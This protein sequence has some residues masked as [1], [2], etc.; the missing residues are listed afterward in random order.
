M[1]RRIMLVCALA[2]VAVVALVAAGCGGGNAS[3]GGGDATKLTLV[4]Y[5]TPQEAYEEIIPAFQK[6]SAGKNVDFEQSYAASG[7]QS[8]AVEA[9]LPADVVAFSLEPDVTRLVD[10]G[11]V[12]ADWAQ[13]DH[14]GMVTDSVA[15]LAVRKGNPKNIQ[16]WDD[17]VQEGVEVIT[18]NPFTSGGARWNL[19]AAYGAQIKQ[20]KSEEEAVDFLRQV[21]KHTAVQDKS[22]REALQTFAGGKGDVL[23]AYENEA[24]TAQQKGEE[25]DYV[26]PDETILIENP[27]AVTEDSPEQAQTFVDFLQ[28]PEAQK[29][30]GE[31][32][33][34]PVDEDILGQFDYPQPSGLFTIKDVGG[35]DEVM[36]KFF[37]R[38]T[39]LVA[40]IESDLGV[41]TESG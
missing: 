38:D 21:L 14:D 25:I 23:I 40:K 31:K 5:S 7:E 30:F 36:T 2:L 6:T 24:I 29:I 3:G 20:G 39:G 27:V 4:A 32:G 17:I 22:A 37:D 33:Y 10:A 26:V 19:M 35:W 11:L 34:R 8:R 16:T 12:S 28:G 13:A 1:I 9:G 15:V 41:S 18:P